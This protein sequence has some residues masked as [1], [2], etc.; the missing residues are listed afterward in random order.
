MHSVWAYLEKKTRG[1]D[2]CVFELDATD[3]RL[4][5]LTDQHIDRLQPEF[6]DWLELFIGQYTEATATSVKGHGWLYDEVYDSQG[7]RL[8]IVLFIDDPKHAA[9]FNLICG[10]DVV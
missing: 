3:E 1:K 4:F 5:I 10:Y 7:S 6:I 8:A 2:N 9:M